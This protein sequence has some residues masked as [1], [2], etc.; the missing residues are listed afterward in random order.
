M[1]PTLTLQT[2]PGHE[3]APAGIPGPRRRRNTERR[4]LVLRASMVMLD[5]IAIAGSLA[6][7]MTLGQAHAGLVPGLIPVALLSAGIWIGSIAWAGGYEVRLLGRRIE[8]TT[9]L[10]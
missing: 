3:P 4:L 9:R 8:L 2:L 1:N 5:L 7:S 10:L 6:V